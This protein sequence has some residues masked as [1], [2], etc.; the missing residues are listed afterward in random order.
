M[1]LTEQELCQTLKLRLSGLYNN[2]ELGLLQDYILKS[3]WFKIYNSGI[4]KNVSKELPTFKQIVDDLAS[5][6]PVQ[7]AIH[8][9]DFMGLVLYVD[10]SV[11]IPRPETEELT[12]WVSQKGGNNS[13][14]K[15]LDV[16]CGSGCISIYLKKKHVHWKVTALDVSAL[17]L[18]VAKENA[19]RVGVTIDFIQLD[20]LKEGD[21]ILDSFDIIV[22]NPPYI[23]KE[24]SNVMSTNTLA[25]EPEIALFPIGD[26]P[27]IFYKEIALFGKSHLKP[28]GEI[29]CE[30]NEFLVLEIHEIFR[31]N[32]YRSIEIRNDMQGKSRMLKAR[33]A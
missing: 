27:L 11:L 9:S 28:E 16:G 17:A 22:S 21:L 12:A 1:L 31:L 29:Y 24:E 14:L 10:S 18:Q 6:V 2:C 3:E 25:Y 4:C 5:M 32:G 13:T 33:M 8:E 20:F 23:S 26:D 19:T 7:Y 30:L 15:V